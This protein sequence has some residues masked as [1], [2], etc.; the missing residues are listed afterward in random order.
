[1]MNWGPAKGNSCHPGPETCSSSPCH[2]LLVLE[3]P[4]DD[5]APALSLVFAWKVG[6]EHS[7]KRSYLILFLCCCECQ[8]GRCLS[9]YLAS[10]PFPVSVLRALTPPDPWA[11]GSAL[12]LS[13]CTRAFLALTLVLQMALSAHLFAPIH[14]PSLSFSLPLGSSLCQSQVACSFAELLSRGDAPFY[15]FPFPRGGRSSL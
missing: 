1:M 5:W 6:R 2:S 13:C 7:Q 4:W 15:S 10:P 8:V 12:S 11:E 3:G 9:W 14:S